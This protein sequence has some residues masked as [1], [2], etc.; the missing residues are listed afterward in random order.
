MPE[1][2]WLN[3]NTKWPM[4]VDSVAEMRGNKARSRPSGGNP[5]ALYQTYN[6]RLSL[7]D[8]KNYKFC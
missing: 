1:I 7:T 5:F 4:P 8:G 2:G 6:N 3:S